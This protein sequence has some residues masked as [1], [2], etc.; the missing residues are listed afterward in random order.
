MRA[1]PVAEHFLGHVLRVATLRDV[2]GA[3]FLTRYLHPCGRRRIIPA[4]PQ[5]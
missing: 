1:Y 5:P 4:L 3:P 2:V